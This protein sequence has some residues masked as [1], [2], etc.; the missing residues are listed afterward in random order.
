MTDP[1]SGAKY[2]LIAA[3]L[4]HRISSGTYPVGAMIPSEAQ[5]VREFAASR[6]TVVRA[7]DHLRQLGYV[8]GV[9]GRGRIALGSP[10][11]L[12][13]QPPSRV[14]WALRAPETLVATLVGAG[15]APASPRVAALLSIP[16]GEPVIARQRLLPM[17]DSDLSTLSTAYIPAVSATGTALAA[18]ERLREGV[19]DHLERRRQ[20]VGTDVLER[21]TARAATAREATLLSVDRG[22]AVLSS[23]LVVRVAAEHPVLVLDQVIPASSYGIDDL[24]RLH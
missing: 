8:E 17:M 4:Q 19:L 18:T 22:V 10:P 14:R 12:A 13:S 7:L 1:S 11:P 16:T 23:I 24:F 20:I 3:T 15:R 5:L 21:L 9:Q 2:A 6:S